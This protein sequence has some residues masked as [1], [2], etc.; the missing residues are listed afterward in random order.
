MFSSVIRKMQFHRFYTGG[1]FE[2]R[3]ERPAFNVWC[4]F[5]P[6]LNG[7]ASD[8]RIPVL[9]W[10]LKTETFQNWPTLKNF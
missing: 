5:G 2:N 7:Q 9:E 1:I 4:R 3:T 6:L 8:F 10:D